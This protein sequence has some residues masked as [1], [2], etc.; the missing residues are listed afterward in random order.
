MKSSYAAYLISLLLFGSNGIVAA[1]VALPSLDIVVIRTLLGSLFL[2]GLLGAL[3]LAQRM[4]KTHEGRFPLP[5]TAV[6]GPP[7][8]AKRRALALQACSG[9]ALG[10]SWICLFEAY[11]AVGV[12]TASLIYY[13]G[14]VIVMALSP[15]LFKEKIS[16]A[17]AGGF[18][19]V[20]AGAF[21]VSVQALEGGTDPRGI[22]LG[23]AS[24][25]A[26]AAMVI[27]SK[28]AALACP[29]TSGSGVRSTFVQLSTGFLVSAGFLALTQGVGALA[30]PVSSRD[31]A[32]L[33]ML[34][35]VNT[36]VGCLLYFTSIGLLPVQT[37]A[38]CGYL[39]PLSAVILSALILGEPLGPAQIAGAALIVGGAAFGEL[40]GNAA[41]RKMPAKPVPADPV[42]HEA[43]RHIA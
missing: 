20:A 10:A 18:T 1:M 39:E 25:C 8:T 5:K 40:S 15:L 19:A 22:V 26:Y 16:A 9:A 34:G 27:C 3:S 32:P 43:K 23:A 12:G 41:A 13:C 28:Q 30:I 7:P 11:R 6:G 2:G 33:L 42:A 35:I 31:I 38:I 21:L 24:A 37:V 36:G 29:Q 14:P 4:G 17:K